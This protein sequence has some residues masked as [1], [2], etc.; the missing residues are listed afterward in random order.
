MP[1]YLSFWDVG[2]VIDYFK[3]LEA[4]EGLTFKKLTVKTVMLLALTNPS[5]SVDLDIQWRS[6]QSNGVTFQ[7]AHLI[8]QSRLSKHLPYFFFPSFKEMSSGDSEGL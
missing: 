1:R 4:N 6:Y 8:K 7:P 5:Q 2:T 3:G